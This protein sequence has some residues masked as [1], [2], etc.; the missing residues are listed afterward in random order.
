MRWTFILARFRCFIGPLLALTL[1]LVAESAHAQAVPVGQGLVAD[2]TELRVLRQF[3]Y[4]TGGPAWNNRTNWLSGTTLAEAG[5]WFGVSVA[6]GDV[7]GLVSGGNN[8]QGR[9]PA[10]LG[11]LLGLTQ[12]QLNGAAGLT[13][14][15]PRELGQLRQLQSLIISFT[16]VSG[17]IPAEIGLLTKLTY[18]SFFNNHLSGP[19]PAQLG[20]LALLQSLYL[21]NYY[22]T[23]YGQGNAYTGGILS[24]LGRLTSLTTL[25][26]SLVPIGGKIPAQL[27]NLANLTFLELDGDQL[28]G[29]V[30]AQLANLT[31]LTYLNVGNNRLT[32][33]PV[34]LPLATPG[35]LRLVANT[36]YFDFASLERNF[37][38]AGTYPFGAF[39]YA[40]QL[41]PPGTDTVRYAQ[42][43]TLRLTRPTGG[44]HNRYQ[45]ERQVGGQWT[46]L[47]GD[48]LAAL[49]RPR[50]TGA[51]QGLYRLRVT[52]TW[53]PNL[54]LYPKLV[55]A[56]WLCGPPVLS[57][58]PAV[59]VE[60]GNSAALTATVAAPTTG[61]TLAW[62]PAAGLSATT[63]PRVT[64]TPAAT[65]TYT[66][67]ATG[68][69]GSAPAATAR[70]TVTVIPPPPL[71]NPPVDGCVP[72]LVNAA[73]TPHVSGPA[74]DSVN[75]VRT[76]APRVALTDTAAV[77]LG[78]KAQV[79]V[80]TEYL[81][82]LGRPV[83]TVLRQESPRGNDLVQP[84]AYDALGRQPRQ[85]QPYAAANPTGTPGAYRPDALG[86]QYLFYRQDPATTPAGPGNLS[87]RVAPTGVAYAETAFE[88]SP[89]NR[90]LAQAA[91]GE[92]WALTP[93]GGHAVRRLERPNTAADAVPR[94][95]PDYDPAPSALA[96]PGDYPAGE[97][98]LTETADEHGLRTQ[99]FKDKQ[100]LIVA[101]RVENP[102]TGATGLANW[103]STYYAYDDFPRLRA[104]VPPKAAVLLATA[105]PAQTVTP[106]AELL[107]FRYRYDGRGRQIAKQVPGQT[108]ETYAVY[109]QLDRP[110]LTQDPA[111][112]ARQE[113]SWLKYDAL[114]RPVC[115][116]LLKRNMTLAAAQAA[117]D[118]AG[119]AP[120]ASSW[121]QRAVPTAARPEGYTLAQAFP[122]LGA[123]G[124]TLF[125]VLT[126]AHFDD[127]NF[128]NDPAG[129]PDAAYD[130]QSDGQ[131]PSGTAPVADARTTGLPTR[132]R[133]RV[134]GVPD[135]DPAAWLTATTFYDERAR[136]VQVQATNARAGLDLLTTRLDFSG[137]PL[138]SVA[139]HHG[140]NLPAA[141]LQVVE[142]MGYDHAGRLLGTRQQVLGS[143]PRP[144]R[145]DS[146][147]YN[148]I[149]QVTRKTLGTGALTQQVDYRYNARGWLTD[150]NDADNPQPGNLFNLALSYDC[151]F[152][153]PQF[154]G[155]IAG[156]KWRGRDGVERAYGYLYDGANRLRQG[157]YVARGPA[158]VW[159]AE[160]QRYALRGVSYDEN[161]NILTLQ[162]RGLWA[163]ATRSMGAQFGPVDNLTYAYTGNRL[164]AVNDAVTSNARPRPAGYNGAPTS[165]AGDFQE[166]GV[167]LGTEYFYDNNGSLTQDKN[168]GITGI[169]YNHLSLPK[170]IRFGIGADSIVFHYSAA[171]QKVAKL[172]YQTG[173]P[174][175]RTDYLGPYQ[176]EQDS[177]RFFPHAE[178]RVLRFAN[179]TSGAVRYAREFTVKD[180]LGNLRLAYRAGQ[181]RVYQA[182]LEQDY[183]THTRESQQFDSLSV[184]PP[185]AVPTGLASRGSYAARLNA[186]GAAPQPL[187]PLTQFA[188]QKGDTIHATAFG[189]Y[190]QAVSTNSFAFS[191]ASFV[192]ALLHPAPAG[193]P[194]GADGSRRGGLPLLQ[195]GL[196]AAA[197]PLLLPQSGG[198][199]R[200]YLRLL[201]FNEDSV[202]IPQQTVTVPL[203][204]SALNNYALLDTQPLILQ[205][206]GYVSVYVGNESA[207]DVYF[208]DV[209]IE[210]RQGLQVQE[211]QYDPFGLDLAGVSGAAPGLTLKNFYQFNGKENQL[212]LGLNWNHQDARFYDYQLGRWHVV[213]PLV[214]AGQEIWTPYQFGYDN[215]VRYNDPDGLCPTCL[216]GAVVG[217]AVDYGF[218][219]AG[220]RLSHPEQSWKESLTNVNGASILISA[221]AGALTGGVSAL[222]MSTART[223]AAEGTILA[224]E[225]VGKQKTSGDGSV[226]AGQVLTD[227][228][229]G[230]V[231]GRLVLGPH[232]VD[233]KPLART[234]DRAERVAANSAR[235]G[236]VNNVEVARSALKRTNAANHLREGVS[237]TKSELIENSGQ[238][239]S[240]TSQSGAGQG[241]SRPDLKRR[242]EIAPADNTRVAPRRRL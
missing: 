19:L 72:A 4:T 146:L 198:V 111:Q 3:Y 145:L 8:L 36:N 38:G 140:P 190:P 28:T 236:R 14:A 181:R 91:P 241:S 180:H 149:G 2:T 57:V 110:V 197:L 237:A 209:T 220:N 169:A 186:G 137:K 219:V 87:D 156:Q 104:V 118:A 64:A 88:P 108:G 40:P 155:N 81:D 214:E 30:P 124:Y 147:A 196:N 183:T 216:I 195:V 121:E 93:T 120:G 109:D 143:D 25:E 165:L 162:R 232:K 176:Y 13:G 235:A 200:G 213:D 52:N 234:L 171:G 177:L 224:A 20:N 46:A 22:R 100:G 29:A 240:G 142:T 51:E 62:S 152:Q 131:F 138:Q 27:G 112:R 44:P 210:H 161:G 90:V 63:G 61:V 136:P 117:A 154:N 133:T 86:E 182:T 123:A 166:A 53:V 103:L 45:W 242:P 21:G 167:R 122:R 221:G 158:G 203:G 150:L 99:E 85:Y 49:T 105:T 172:V 238:T 208:D 212:D 223:L 34:L 218:Q 217:A 32:Q 70:V 153:V 129:I 37:T 71:I 202:L 119:T 11:K 114:G 205:Q 227:V 139:V 184:S 230:L 191:L 18:L 134:L 170:L 125:Q 9:V 204:P 159:N 229:V 98:W 194:P 185:M 68:P 175:L 141:G 1:V 192:A 33:L 127:Y 207:A 76:Y 47:P 94:F 173:K 201:V 228:G 239:A 126:L 178:G 168:K 231:V 65:T 151:G 132:S 101:K 226:N 193:A 15:L 42:G 79:Q 54:T 31:R 225:S 58:S 60:A 6:G 59:S 148:E 39:Y 56:K 50:A 222:E 24:A 26:L 12:L 144:V 73:P 157:D 135:T 55:Y 35:P 215:A 75:F 116:G 41:T 164:Q 106:A 97:L 211:N 77:R 199:P 17:P 174:V 5:T 179:A 74:D 130:P 84:V 89:L 10:S 128:D 23:P 82:G 160:T 92:A 189:L 102:V 163:N 113:W 43:S 95:V 7:T 233:T 107:L 16:G 83:Q 69:C 115:T 78:T 206:N 187:G 96:Y 48:T 66:V 188:V 67:T 80:R